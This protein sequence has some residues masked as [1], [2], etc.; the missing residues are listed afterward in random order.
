MGVE[1]SK[2]SHKNKP[3]VALEFLHEGLRGGNPV[4]RGVEWGQTVEGLG[5]TIVKQCF[6][7]EH[8]VFKYAIYL[9]WLWED[10]DRNLGC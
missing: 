3:V 5:V 1:I 10:T 9:G 4:R 8:T 6:P 7:S 2:K